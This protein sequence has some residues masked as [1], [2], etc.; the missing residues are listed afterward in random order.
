MNFEQTKDRRMLA[1]PRRRHIEA[2][3]MSSMPL[4]PWVVTWIL[5]FQT[6]PKASS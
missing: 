2:T 4:Q 6:M 3:R 1:G 5:C